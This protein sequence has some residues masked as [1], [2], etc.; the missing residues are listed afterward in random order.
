[1]SSLTSLHRQEETVDKIKEQTEQPIPTPSQPDS[2]AGNKTF[3][4]RVY[5]SDQI[6]KLNFVMKMEDDMDADGNVVSEKCYLC[7]WF[8]EKNNYLLELG[9]RHRFHKKCMEMHLLTSTLCPTCKQECLFTMHA[10]TQKKAS[11]EI[12]SSVSSLSKTK[13]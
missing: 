6:D 10:P 13:E 11:V 3:F 5:T 12:C 7:M 2:K 9:C 4:R 8:I 1:M